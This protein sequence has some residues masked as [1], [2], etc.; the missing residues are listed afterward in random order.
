MNSLYH[1]KRTIAIGDVHGC[2]SLLEALLQKVSYDPS[3]D[4]LVFVGDL[5]DRGPNPLGVVRLVRRLE[6]EGSVITLKGNHEDK[7]V[8]FFQKEKRALETGKPNTMQK[9]PV[10]RLLQWY[11]FGSGDL[12]WLE[13]LPICVQVHPEWLAV[14]AGFEAVPM[15][16]Q[17]SDRMMRVRWVKKDSGEY[18]PTDWDADDPMRIPDHA[19]CWM[20][21]WKGPSH[22]VYGHAIHGLDQPR[23]DR[24]FSGV[25]TWGIDTGA[26]AGGHLTAL[27]L[28][29]REV[30][31]VRDGQVFGKWLGAWT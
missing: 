25:E 2:L 7:M 20:D 15:D 31:Q 28:E 4:R 16:Q 12:Q 1:P 5:I 30:T 26:Y 3:N 11:T 10:H 13:R 29:T 23:V 9:P 22:V 18:V 6:Q 21:L 14:H 24:P 27:I 19:T 8:R 17:K